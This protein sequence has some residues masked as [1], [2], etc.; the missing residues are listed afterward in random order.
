MTGVRLFIATLFLLAVAL[1][2]AQRLEPGTLSYTD[3]G[4]FAHSDWS[5]SLEMS[6][7]F[8]PRND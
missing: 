5:V 3:S 7:S 6:G 8:C 1:A 4:T 2:S